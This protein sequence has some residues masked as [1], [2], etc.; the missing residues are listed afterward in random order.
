MKNRNDWL[1]GINREIEQPVGMYHFNSDTALLGQFLDL[2]HSD[3]VLDAGC[4]TGALLLYASC[5][6]PASLAGIDL[7]QEQ[8]DQT[9]L[10]LSRYDLTAEL[11]VSRLQDYAHAPFDALII[12][13]PYFNTANS[14]LLSDNPYLCA[15][16]HERFLT[17]EELF[18]HSA[19]LLKDN[20]RLYLVHRVSRL[21]ELV[22]M[23]DQYHFHTVRMQIA[24]ESEHGQGKSIAIKFKKAPRSELKI[25]AP[26][27]LK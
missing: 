22:L 24:Y 19:R 15:A 9:A 18:R 27:F 11:Q 6:K 12:N 10:N 16:R 7:Y 23:A 13:P 1:P 2:K 5:Q 3:H 14:D 20:G 21:S 26:V 8:I 17:M 4:N 25:D